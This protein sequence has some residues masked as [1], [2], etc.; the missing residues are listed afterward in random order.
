MAIAC[1]TVGAASRDYVH[2][3]S[4]TRDMSPHTLRAYSADLAAFGRHVG[5][6]AP[7]AAID[8]DA[9]VGFIDAQRAAGLAASSVKR[10]AAAVRGFFRWLVDESVLSSNPW[11]GVA[12]IGARRRRLPRSVQSDDL[13]R[14]MRWLHDTAGLPTVPARSLR[15]DR[16][17]EST[18][19]VAVLLMVATGI[20]VGELVSVN[21]ADVDLDA[22]RLRITGKGRR[23]RFVFLTNVWS[24]ELLAS[25]LD[26]RTEHASGHDHLLFNRDGAPLDTAAVRARLAYAADAAGIRTRI[27]PHMLRHTA[28]TQLVEAGVDI[29]VIQ[30]LLGHASLSTTEIY[31]HVADLTLRRMV[32]EADVLGRVVVRR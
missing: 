4:T 21:C 24:S 30:R 16:P 25:Y 9:V 19:L 6:S 5:D 7:V 10:R 20:R 28:A 12:V 27:T 32:T 11:S 22:Q 8:R 29:R 23:E 15:V 1:T 26:L 18:T 13:A 31:T 17:H 2:W 14:L 3:L